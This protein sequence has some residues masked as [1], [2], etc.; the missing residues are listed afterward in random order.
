[1]DKIISTKLLAFIP[2]WFIR[3]RPPHSAICR[4]VGSLLWVQWLNCLIVV[5]I[6]M[7]RTTFSLQC[8]SRKCPWDSGSAPAERGRWLDFST[9]PR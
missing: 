1:M 9:R 7:H 4:C 3:V 5:D 6:Y 2:E 8:Q